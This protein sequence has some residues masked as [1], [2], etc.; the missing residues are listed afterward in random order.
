MET[1]E[2]AMQLSAPDPSRL[3]EIARQVRLDIIEMLYRASSGGHGAPALYAV[4]G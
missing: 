4:L 1:T 3:Q 2:A